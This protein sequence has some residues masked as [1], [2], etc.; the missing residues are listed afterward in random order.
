MSSKF[1]K[2]AIKLLKKT[3]KRAIIIIAERSSEAER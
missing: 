2:K 1:R 3:H